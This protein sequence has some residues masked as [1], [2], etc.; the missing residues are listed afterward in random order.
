M[1]RA[2]DAAGRDAVHAYAWARFSGRN[3][4][5]ECQPS[6]LDVEGSSPFARFGEAAAG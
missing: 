6:M 1:I 3:S 2:A 5:V 4:M